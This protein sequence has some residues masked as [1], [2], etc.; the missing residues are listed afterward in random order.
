[1]SATTIE[2]QLGTLEDCAARCERLAADDLA[3]AIKALIW[4]FSDMAERRT[5]GARKH[6][7]DAKR[8]RNEARSQEA[9]S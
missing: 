9:K 3:E 2:P 8:Y 4:G 6:L 7:R 1:V 5:D